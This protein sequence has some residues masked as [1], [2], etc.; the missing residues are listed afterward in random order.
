MTYGRTGSRG[1]NGVRE[2]LR[3][4]LGRSP[5]PDEMEKQINRDKGYGGYKRT[6]REDSVEQDNRSKQE[7]SSDNSMN[8]QSTKAISEGGDSD[9][10]LGSPQNLLSSADKVGSPQLML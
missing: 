10:R 8:S 7:L 3:E 2:R 4:I 6:R 9:D 5:D 1:I